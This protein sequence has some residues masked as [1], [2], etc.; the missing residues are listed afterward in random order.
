MVTSPRT[1][2]PFESHSSSWKWEL[3]SHPQMCSQR[4]GFVGAASYEAR[5]F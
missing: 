4:A 3:E 2:K 5:P 1:G